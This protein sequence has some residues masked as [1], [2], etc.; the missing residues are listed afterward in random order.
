MVDIVEDYFREWIQ[1]K[2]LKDSMIAV[3]NKIRDIPYAIIPDLNDPVGF[4]KILTRNRGSCAPKH[5]LLC[6]MFQKLGLQVLYTVYPFR[7]DEFENIYPSDLRELARDMP[8]SH[9]I[10]CKVD[11]GGRLVLV[12]ATLDPALEVLGLPVNKDWDGINDTQ[13]PVKPCGEEQLYHP[14]EARRIQTGQPD[15]VALAFYYGLNS[16]LE[17]LRMENYV[18][19]NR[20]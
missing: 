19:N 7:W 16:W 10:A 9:H 17:S 5:F 14:T 15:E 20:F 3:F 18:R 13:L 2:N 12:D 11:I 4:A 6:A 1:G 8:V